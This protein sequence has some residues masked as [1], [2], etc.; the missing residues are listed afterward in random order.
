MTMI[1]KLKITLMLSLLLMATACGCAQNSKS[2]NTFID[3]SKLFV[4]VDK[5]F[6]FIQYD[7]NHLV[8]EGDSVALRNFARKWW[9]LLESGKG[10]ITVMQIGASH[11]QGGSFP[12]QIR[13]DLIMGACRAL[14]VN[15]NPY[16]TF[17]VGPRG[18]LFPYSAAQKCNNPFDYKVFRSRPLELTRNV[19]KEP[20]ARL[21]LCGIAVTA[22]DSIAEVGIMMNERDIAFTTNEITV[23]GESPDN[24]VPR[25]RL[26]VSETKGELLEPD[27]ID[28][29]GRRFIY[30][31]DLKFD[32]ITIIMPCSQGQSF[33]LTG[34]LLDN[35]LPGI[36]FHSIG[37]NGASVNDYLKKCPYLKQD[38]ALVKPDLVIFGIGINDAAGTTFDSVAFRKKYLSLVDSIRTVSPEC[39]FIF[40]TNN[41]SYRSSGRKRINNDHGP[42]ARDAF[43]RIARQCGGAVWDQFEIMGGL[44]SI[45]KWNENELAARD[46][47]HFTRKG[48]QLLGD[49]LSNAIFDMLINM[50]NHSIDSTNKAIKVG[51]KQRDSET[52]RTYKKVKTS[53]DESKNEIPVYISY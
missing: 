43:Y 34:I 21:G 17:P 20:E 7:A 15:D 26:S 14:N 28:P 47:V 2:N 41:D 29:A 30:H 48:Y 44:E 6:D 8:I 36:T 35:D 24:V 50:R 33:T 40:I 31:T 42:M 13:R 37:V 32:T 46:K 19:Y 23:F 27:S 1:N 4:S 18:M 11:V 45:V 49:M 3:E 39:A 38:L 9:R 52:P 22:R 25:L 53:T 51:D 5:S 16:A 10:N 12:H